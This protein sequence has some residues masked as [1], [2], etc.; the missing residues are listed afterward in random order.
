MHLSLGL[1]MAVWAGAVVAAKN[2]LN[3]VP[4]LTLSVLRW[5]VATGAIGVILLLQSR[6]DRLAMGGRDVPRA[7]LM[8]VL[9]ITLQYSLFYVG[10]Q[11]TTA[12]N[13]ALIFG[14]S[15]GLTAIL[16]ALFLGEKLDARRA[17]GLVVA[18][19]GLLLLVTGGSLKQ[20]QLTGQYLGDLT[21]LLTAL[22]WAGYSVVGKPLFSRNPSLA[23][24]FHVTWIGT[25][26]LIP[27]A[28]WEG[29]QLGVSGLSP[30]A[31]LAVAY[32]GVLCSAVAFLIW[33]WALSQIEASQVGVYVYIEPLVTVLLASIFL[34][35]AVTWPV[36]IGGG[37]VLGGIAFV[38]R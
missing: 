4:P 38:G 36:V 5:M 2:A 29:R 31:W 11:Y 37:L 33:N 23:T 10:L 16:S 34:G 8:G 17:L 13:A 3:E 14:T 28:V 35:E 19:T 20:V 6:G 12:T 18:F 15:P 25:L 24:T 1:S 32:M 7:V 30:S 9:G 26:G 27:L 21:I 22:A